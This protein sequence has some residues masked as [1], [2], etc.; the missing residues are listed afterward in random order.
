[1]KKWINYKLALYSLL[2]LFMGTILFHAAV[3]SGLVRYD[4]VWAGRLHNETEMWIMESTSIVAMI[5]FSLIL[6]LKAGYLPRFVPARWITAMLWMMVCFF[7]L[8]TVGNLFA[9]NA[10]EVWLFAPITLLTAI[11]S[12]RI[13]LEKR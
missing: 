8:N 4:M 5:V 2:V 9:M 7:S 12:S 6:C 11:F 3:L 13:A 10:V 1:M